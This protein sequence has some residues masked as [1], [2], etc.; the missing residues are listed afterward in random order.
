MLPQKIN[1]MAA[2]R[3]PVGSYSDNEEIWSGRRGSNP[4]PR[5]WQGRALPL[6]YTRILDGGDRSPATPE[7][8]QMRTANATVRRWSNRA[9]GRPIGSESPRKWCKG[10]LEQD[11]F[12]SNRHPAL[13]YCL[14]MIF[15]EN[16]CPP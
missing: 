4:R 10:P 12:S 5:P 9:I 16:R 13:Y 6:S 1:D 14:S 11:D 8:C 3:R 7:L 15:S 2:F